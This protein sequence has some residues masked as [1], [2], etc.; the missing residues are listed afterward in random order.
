MWLRVILND[1]RCQSYVLLHG[2]L[3]LLFNY[4]HMSRRDG[5]C[6]HVD[7]NIKGSQTSLKNVDYL[8]E[9]LFK[10]C[11]FLILSMCVKLYFNAY[12]FLLYD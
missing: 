1:H 7:N 6:D 9:K 8:S 5:K 10:S 3:L 4:L 2:L 11:H 12:D